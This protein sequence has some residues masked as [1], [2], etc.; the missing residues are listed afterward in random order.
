M[1]GQL[2][3]EIRQRKPFANIEQE[4]VLNVMRTA[5]V[6]RQGTASVLR[7]HGLTG[8]Q[9]NALRILRGAGEDGLPCNEVGDRL[10]SQDPDVTRLFDRMEKLDLVQR[11]RSSSDRRVV[12]ARLTPRGLDLVNQLDGPMAQTHAGQLKHMKNKDLNTLIDLLE[13]VRE[14]SAGS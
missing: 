14:E 9:Y 10:V 4:V 2:R 11:K 12:I 1:T 8:P 5:S 7:E 3:K 6:L 13:A